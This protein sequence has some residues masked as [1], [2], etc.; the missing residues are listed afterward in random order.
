MRLTIYGLPLKRFSFYQLLIF[1]CVCGKRERIDEL[2]LF[3]L[4]ERARHEERK[5]ESLSKTPNQRRKKEQSEGWRRKKR[6]FEFL[7]L[8]KRDQ[9]ACC[10]SFYISLVKSGEKNSILPTMTW[11]SCSWYCFESGSF[12]SFSFQSSVTTPI[13]LW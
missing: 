10:R 3:S 1:M 9:K 5:Q 2:S 4:I 8:M 7:R 11:F 6:E 12:F 13:E